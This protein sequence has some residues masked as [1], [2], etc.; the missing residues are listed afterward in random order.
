MTLAAATMDLISRRWLKKGQ[1]G[2]LSH[3]EMVVEMKKLDKTWPMAGW[4]AAAID[5][6]ATVRTDRVKRAAAGAWQAKLD[7]A[8][9]PAPPLEA[10]E[11]DW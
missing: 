1:P 5:L 4:W 7:A 3:E 2:S 8:R 9:A 10:P 6:D 11:D